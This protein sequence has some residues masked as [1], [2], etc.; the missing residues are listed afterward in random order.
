MSCVIEIYDITQY[1]P[2]AT[3]TSVCT[4][5]GYT[6]YTIAEGVAE[7]LATLGWQYRVA[8]EKERRKKYDS[9]VRDGPLKCIEVVQ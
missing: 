4:N 9:W 6:H 5:L 7:L 3:I 1:R 2:P 8:T